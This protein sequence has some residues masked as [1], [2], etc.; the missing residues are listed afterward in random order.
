M[1]AQIAGERMNSMI[2]QSEIITRLASRFATGTLPASM[3]LCGPRGVGK[4]TAAFE[5]ARRITC[6]RPT[7]AFGC[8]ECA[9]CRQLEQFAHPDVQ[10]LFPLPANENDWD[11]WYSPYLNSKQE[12]PFSQSAADAKHFIP[13]E[14]IR[15]FQ[16]KLSRRPTLSAYKV[17][18][19]YEAERMLPGT[20]DSLLKLL[21]EPPASSFL[22][23]VTHEPRFLIPTILSR[24]QRI[25]LPALEDGFVRTYLES[26]Y[27]IKDQQLEAMVRFARGQ[28]YDIATI[29]EGDFLQMRGSALE[30]IETALSIAQPDVY[31]RLGESA[32]LATREKVEA[33]LRHWQTILR[34]VLVV[35]SGSAAS[36]APD[37]NSRLLNVDFRERYEV[38][39]EKIGGLERIESLSDRLEAIKGELRRNVNPRMAG[40]SF[41]F[42]L[43]T[44]KVSI[45]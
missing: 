13:I 37:T 44:T 36:T 25:N 38:L 30:M 14:A 19:I 22:M 27:S 32:A 43:S 45:R 20:M 39:A 28:L 12:N 41:L 5:L 31:T 34:D 40:L 3:L 4:W 18:I 1:V 8:G 9:S 6:N 10:F 17:G 42:Q 33:L 15:Q 11:A 26:K 7:E 23:V 21:E 16:S 24:L 35:Q 29:L 2:P